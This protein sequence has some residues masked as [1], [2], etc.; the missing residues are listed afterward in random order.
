MER[1]AHTTSSNGTE[2]E[3]IRNMPMDKNI[4]PSDGVYYFED[5]GT[6]LKAEV[7]NTPTQLRI[8]LIDDPRILETP[9]LIDICMEHLKRR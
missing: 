8:R 9:D 3:N 6:R 4:Y 7:K 5:G 2:D 1:H